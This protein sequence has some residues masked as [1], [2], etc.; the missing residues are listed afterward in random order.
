MHWETKEELSWHPSNNP[1]V[2]VIHAAHFSSTSLG[3]FHA[4][5]S[6]ANFLTRRPVLPECGKEP[7]PT[8]ALQDNII[9]VRSAATGPVDA[10]RFIIVLAHPCGGIVASESYL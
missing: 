5:L 4:H 1:A 10:G 6:E 2:F 8:T 7:P 9:T 3:P